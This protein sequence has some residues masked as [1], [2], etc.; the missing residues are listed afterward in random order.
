MNR[1]ATL[2]IVVL[3]CAS[4]LCGQTQPSNSTSSPGNGP[5]LAN[6]TAI[7]AKLISGLDTAQC[8]PGD[9]V[10]AQVVHDVKQGSQ[11][12]VKRGLVHG[13]MAFRG[14]L[15]PYG[16]TTRNTTCEPFTKWKFPFFETTIEMCDPFASWNAT[17]TS[18]SPIAPALFAVRSSTRPS[19]A[20]RWPPKSAP[21]SLPLR[22]SVP[23]VG[24]G[25][26]AWI[27]MRN[28]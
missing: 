5:K 24:G 1:L 23:A 17:F 11:V 26:T 18:G 15:T 10:D 2:T 7:I 14:Y 22:L 8:K 20:V 3:G 21:V 16:P 4:L 13:Q 25:A 12:V 9:S 6:G 27:S 28:K 19:T